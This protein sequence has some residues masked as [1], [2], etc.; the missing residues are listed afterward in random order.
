MFGAVRPDGIGRRTGVAVADYAA[1]MGGGG[2]ARRR[3]P[4]PC[5]RA[6]L[7]GLVDDV[8]GPTP[9]RLSA[10][11]PTD[12]NDEKLLRG[13]STVY[14]LLRGTQRPKLASIMALI[15][16]CEEY[17]KRNQPRARYQEL[18]KAGRFDLDRLA[19]DCADDLTLIRGRFSGPASAR[20]V[21]AMRQSAYLRQVERIAPPVLLGRETELA[22]LAM[23]CTM[24]G[25]GMYAWWRAGAWAGKT[26][27][28][29]TFVLHPPRE[30][31]DRVRLMSFFITARL[32]AQDT[33]DAF[34]VVM[35]EQLADLIGQGP[36]P[37][38]VPE[39]REAVLLDLLS[40]GAYECQAVGRRLVLVV[41]GLD[42]DRS[43]ITGGDAHSIAGLLPAAPPAGM[44]VVVA[45]RPNPPIPDDVPAW[46]PLRDRLIV[47]SLKASTYARDLQ[48]LSKAELHRLLN[49]TR[50]Q[51]ELLGLLTAAKGGLSGFDLEEL[52]EAPLWQIE[53][54]LHTVAGRTFTRRDSV[55]VQKT[56]PEVY[57]LGH[58][59]LQ[60]AAT[61]Y[62]GEQ[63]LSGYRER[64]HAWAEDYRQRG[65]PTE[66]PEYLL[67]G[68]FR[69]LID[70]RD[71]PRLIAHATDEARHDRML[72]LSGGDA[73]AV[74]EVTIAQQYLLSRDEPDLL[75]LVR[76][77][78]RRESLDSRNFNMPTVLPAVWALMGQPNRAQA[79]ARSIPEN[80]GVWAEAMLGVVETAAAS[81]HATA[82]ALARTITDTSARAL[83]LA[84]V[85]EA[86][87]RDDLDRARALIDEAEIMAT[88]ITMLG[89]RK[90]V[91]V[92]VVKA[93]ASIG[94][95]EKAETLARSIA[96]RGARAWALVDVPRA[97]ANAGTIH[98]A[99]ILI[100]SNVDYAVFAA[101]AVA[102]AREGCN[103][104]AQSLA[105]RAE[106]VARS[107]P[108]EWRWS[109][110]VKVARAV[111]AL[112]DLDRARTL[113]NEVQTIA[114]STDV[115]WAGGFDDPDFA[116]AEIARALVDIGDYDK[117]DAVAQSI[118]GKLYEQD[119]ALGEVAA[120]MANSPAHR[121]RAEA[122]ARSVTFLPLRLEALAAV[123]KTMA[124]GDPDRSR[125]LAEEVESIAR[126]GALS[127][128]FRP[129]RREMAMALAEV[130]DFEGATALCRD[131]GVIAQ[132]AATAGYYDHAEEWAGSITIAWERCRALLGVAKIVAVSGDLDRAEAIARAIGDPDDRACGLAS[133]AEAA[134]GASDF[135]RAG[136]LINEAER[137]VD[138]LEELDVRTPA[139]LAQ[140]AAAT[141]DLERAQAMAAKIS[142]HPGYQEEAWLAAIETV[143][144]VGDLDRAESLTRAITEPDQQ[145]RGLAAVAEAA[146]HASDLQRARD[147]I[148]EAEHIAS[149]IADSNRQSKAL[150]AVARA[151]A[152]VAD[153]DWA[154]SV[155]NSIPESR[156]LAEALIDIAGQADPPRSR[157]L[158]ARVLSTSRWGT[159]LGLLTRLEP[160][161]LT[162][163]PPADANVSGAPAQV[164]IVAPVRS[165]RE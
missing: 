38:V 125:R 20:P 9:A 34:I 129:W 30:V 116:R 122:I 55:W 21:T 134:A 113:I 67:R 11:A 158:A 83:A 165:C 151:A 53:E 106:T 130:G 93:W 157:R 155:A 142:N 164:R 41:D 31:Q 121:D 22:E 48:R 47:R 131:R 109:A 150:A 96:D 82:E 99:G 66:T 97:L 101:A 36:P 108:L 60:S 39:T 87:A 2:S 154:V 143:A 94:E 59:E 23:F 74:S 3:D 26:A 75:A 149:N 127:D 64:L 28:L 88:S 135:D 62:L 73:A 132:A 137:L 86:M 8:G 10:L 103:D 33:R 92:G 24:P 12:E 63:R 80:T 144:R 102:A 5:L 162:L 69:M 95:L 68:Y 27:L 72:D 110:L 124:L 54:V 51:R 105:D 71:T 145:A 13:R 52:A 61:R 70:V 156:T 29:S 32:A 148:N 139:A 152:A 56:G 50:V 128:P 111:A 78:I 15:A 90:H 112:G 147:L 115:E 44:R 161:V 123:A 84:T 141:A 46:H 107:Q 126:R 35:L 79:L 114:P 133:V 159:S 40:Q 100:S 18:K 153:F 140:A 119:E 17:S 45:G 1:D 77:A 14:D 146:S 136:R 117:A 85:A 57:L 118:S 4:I 91:L 16:A 19:A 163:V 43:V 160:A 25:K 37:A 65:W 6:A 81:D 58:E 98:R 76:L 42:E 89:T 49:G 138:S 104:R 7:R 120:A